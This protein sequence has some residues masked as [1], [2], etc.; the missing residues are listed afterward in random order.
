M[1]AEELRDYLYVQIPIAR[2]MAVE[3]VDPGPDRVV[4][5]A[6]LSP[7]TNHRSTAFG[8]SVSALAT[9]AG[10]A[11]IH[12]RLRSAGRD[13]QVV[14]QR[15]AIDYL[16]P[17]TG[18]FRAACHGVDPEEWRRMQRALDR[19]GRGRAHVDVRVESAGTPV[20]TFRGAYVAILPATE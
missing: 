14:I 6:P 16:L 2:A 18:A 8:G 12:G 11:L 10:W 3:V 1:T 7:N 15:G 5:E 4:L 19:V 17:I 9:L 20:A 13:S